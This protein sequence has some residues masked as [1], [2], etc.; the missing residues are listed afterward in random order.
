MLKRM[1]L[2]FFDALA[3]THDQNRLPQGDGGTRAIG[4]R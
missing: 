2:A 4:F 3:A 1:R